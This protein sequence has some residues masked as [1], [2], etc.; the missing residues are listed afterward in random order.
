[1]AASLASLRSLLTCHLFKEAFSL[2]QLFGLSLSFYLVCVSVYNGSVYYVFP[3]FL[4]SCPF[5]NKNSLET[6][7]LF[8]VPWRP[9]HLTQCL[10][11]SRPSFSV[12]WALNQDKPMWSLPR[13]D[14]SCRRITRKLLGQNLREGGGA[15]PTQK[16]QGWHGGFAD[17]FTP[18]PLARG[19]QWGYIS[20]W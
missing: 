2:K 4:P 17:F 8:C 20:L 3:D 10:V 16:L 19:R 1:M 18:W 14:P 13:R 5:Y 7:T 11:H 6:G 12:R 9:W 15:G